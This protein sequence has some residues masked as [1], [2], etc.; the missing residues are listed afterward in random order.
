MLVRIKI[1]MARCYGLVRIKIL[2]SPKNKVRTTL[3]QTGRDEFF[4]A[5][6]RFSDLC[7]NDLR[8]PLKLVRYV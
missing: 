3:Q 4:I 7:F 2:I 1:L 8:N 6:P 5:K